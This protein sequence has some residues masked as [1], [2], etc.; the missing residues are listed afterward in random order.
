[1]SK[2]SKPVKQDEKKKAPE[3]KISFA[4][5]LKKMI[6]KPGKKSKNE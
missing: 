5:P 4:D 2:K 6:K 3:D 1:M